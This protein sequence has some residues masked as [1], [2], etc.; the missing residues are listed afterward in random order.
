MYTC[1]F[2]GDYTGKSR[3][4]K[5]ENNFSCVRAMEDPMVLTAAKSEDG[6]EG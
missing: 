6:S 3:N 5:T 2:R 1:T 4:V